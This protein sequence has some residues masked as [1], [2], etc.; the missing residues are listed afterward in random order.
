[1]WREK[2]ESRAMRPNEW[3]KAVKPID[4]LI[5]AFAV[6]VVLMVIIFVA[7]GI[8]PFGE[9]SFLR[10]D[11]YHQYAP[12]FSEFQ[13]KLKNGGSL[14]YS[15]DIGMGVNFTAIYAYY[16]ASPFNWLL[17]FV[18]KAYV[19]EFMTYLI[20]VKT[21]LAGLAMAWYL[22]KHCGT[23]SFAVAFFGIFYAMSGYMA[24]YSW[25]IMWLD[26]IVIF[27]LVVLALENLVHK[28]NF[29]LYSL[30][31]GVCILSNYYIS[32]MICI[33]LVIYFIALLILEKEMTPKKLAKRALAFT[34]G[35]LLAGAL[36]AVTL[37]PE[38]FALEATASADSTFPTTFSQ[39]FSIFDMIARHLPNVQPEEGLDHWPNIYC[40][41]AV[42][43]LFVLYLLCRQISVR[44]KA[45]YLT[46]LLILLGSFALN[47]PNF[48]WHG[49][50][51]PNSLPC[52][53]S[54]I[55]IFLVLLI[56]FEACVHIAEFPSRQ[57]F[58]AFWGAVVFIL[59]AQKLVT[60][61][62]FHFIVYYAA[63]VFLALYLGVI[64][65]YRQGG[66]YHVTALV[67]A[68]L[69]VALEAGVNMSVTSIT[70]TSRTA[71]V[72]DN[73]DVRTLVGDARE[74]T[75]DFFRMTKV[76]IRSKDDGA[77]MNYPSVSLFSSTASADMSALMKKLGCESSTNAYG[78]E[79]LTPL[80]KALFSVRFGM[81]SEQPAADGFIDYSA[82][83]GSTW[84]YRN[85]YCLP[86]GF[87]VDDAFEAR[88]DLETGNPADVQNSFA[89]AVGAEPFF[90]YID[91]V[92][93]DGADLILTA[94]YDGLYY[95]YVTNHRASDVT[96]MT[97]DTTT[98]Y[99]NVD[100]GYL[101]S[102]GFCEAG[103]EVTLTAKDE[104]MRAN[105]YIASAASLQQ[106]CDELM[107]GPWELSYWDDTKL[108]GTVDAGNGGVLFTSIPYDEGWTV[109]VDGEECPVTK[110]L[111][112]F[113][114][115]RLPA[116][117]HTV[118]MKYFPRGLAAGS[119]IS[120]AA[121]VILIICAV[122]CALNR[123][124]REKNFDDGFEYFEL[125]EE[126][127]DEI[128]GYSGKENEAQTQDM[129]YNVSET[130]LSDESD[131]S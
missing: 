27:P 126:P 91:D 25:N 20:V 88:V 80:T 97:A 66:R 4:G 62:H 99:E 13:Y 50:H 93:E 11:M 43:M 22:R 101:L 122:G 118:E 92:W 95:A 71:Y 53:Q 120:A 114:S 87:M 37:L 105:I 46:L 1:M 108:T 123:R 51:Y 35:S 77:W 106:I 131:I 34:G 74:Q 59:L 86:L 127:E 65:L 16:L 96:V 55:Y 30:A 5:L 78:A 61:E 112:A 90:T 9:Q 33:F 17:I 110:I 54:F 85:R 23:D 52:R 31:L 121:L 81:Y 69:L 107:N 116:G 18:P 2:K 100:R 3:E 128:P 70:T 76:K 42:L 57:I 56:C 28:G 19:L 7:R 63:I 124:R 129:S 38:F 84:M 6:P 82:H 115:V 39:Y 10:T 89:R 12:F 41:V 58:Y 49:F 72:K 83:E 29:I 109:V 103:D 47:L 44:E 15:W 24:A 45:V 26:C 125:E 75:D 111:G 73:E 104:T 130:S 117:T 48:I 68:L 40:G 98:V 119:L 102:L 36:S 14:L 60:Q 64:F 8:F 113:L 21:G 67:A 94:P 32:I 79:G